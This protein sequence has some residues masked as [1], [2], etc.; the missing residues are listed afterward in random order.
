MEPIAVNS[1]KGMKDGDSFIF[2]NFRADR[3]RQL[4][5]ALCFDGFDAFKREKVIKFSAELQMTEYSKEHSKFMDTMFSPEVVKDSLGE[6]VSNKKLKQLRIAETE[7]YAHVTFFF[8]CGIEKPY[9]GEDRIL[10]KSPSVA[11]YDLQPEMSAKEIGVR[12]CEEMKKQEYS[13]IVVNFANA[14]MVGHTGS[15]EATIKAIKTL[16]EELRKLVEVVL[17]V[18]G[19][20]LVTADHGNAEKMFDEEKNQPHTAHTTNKVPFI[21]V[22][23]EASKITLSKGGSLV[24]I[25]PTVLNI[26]NIKAPKVM[27]GK[28]LVSFSSR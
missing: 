16:D 11:T 28:S 21:V 2:C 23:N 14:D 5:R 8:N 27:S 25:A 17:S 6:V 9:E 19:T 12:L 3:A 7:K 15:K 4:T 13:F 22:S 20:I 18:D 26:L 1:Y 10:V 24:D